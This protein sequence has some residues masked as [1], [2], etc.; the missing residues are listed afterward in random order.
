ME[1]RSRGVVATVALVLVLV[2]VATT[3]VRQAELRDQESRLESA[4]VGVEATLEQEFTRVFDLGYAAQAA[5]DQ[6]EELD[7]ERYA[8]LMEEFGIPGRYPT[9]ISASILEVVD[10][11]DLDERV[12]TRQVQGP[13]E[14]QEDAG[15]PTL[16]LFTYA[17][18]PEVAEDVLGFD[19]T[20]RPDSLLAHQ[21]ALDSGAPRLSSVTQII[22]LDE[23]APGASIHIPVQ[24][25]DSERPATLGVVLAGQRFLDELAPLAR[26]VS[27]R[28]LDPESVLFPVFAETGE[29]PPASAPRVT[30]QLD[31]A[32]RSWNIEVAGGPGFAVPWA[33]RGSTYLGSAGVVVAVLLGLLAWTAAGRE[34]YARELAAR[35]TRE[36]VRANEELAAAGRYKDEFLASVSHELRTP[37]TVISGFADTMERVPPS[38]RTLDLVMPIQRNVRRLSRLVEDL[39]TLASLDAGGLEAHPE[40]IDLGPLL[41]TAASELAG[42]DPGD[43]HVEVAAGTV[44]WMDPRHL[45]RAITNLLTNAGQHGEPPI[46]LTA[47]RLDDGRVEVA[48]R[49]HGLGVAEGARGDLFARFARGREEIRSSGTGLGLAI[50]RELVEIG[51]GELTYEDAAPGARFVLRLPTPRST[52]DG[53][54][55]SSTSSSIPQ[56]SPA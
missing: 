26:G 4:A 3:L 40:P 50:V 31:V 17:H 39:L 6:V 54:T 5:F 27:V 33:Q 14:L 18:P 13:F 8:Q 9:M 16:R 44:V 49:D 7:P 21:G 37:L 15:E 56:S 46:H 35:R 22:Q 47:R 52:P 29:P 11:D 34:G 48:V 51:G 23:G 43:V 28:V 25:P 30:R 19:L 2:A 41:A 12:A 36:L 20:A 38:A 45:E 24:L 32:G 1:A 55:S 53:T 42:L 10:R